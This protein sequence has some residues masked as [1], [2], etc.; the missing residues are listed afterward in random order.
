MPAE[1]ISVVAVADDQNVT[2]PADATAA[3]FS[4]TGWTS[5]AGTSLGT[6]TLG[7]VVPDKAQSR[8]ITSSESGTG[9][10]AWR[11]PPTGLQ[12]LVF[13]FTPDDPMDEGPTCFVTF[14]KGGDTNLLWRDPPLSD[15][16]GP[17]TPVSV[18]VDTVAGDLVVKHDQRFQHS[19]GQIPGLSSG[20]TSGQTMENNQEGA[21]LSYIVATGT[22]QVCDSEDEDFSTVLAFAIPVAPSG[23]GTEFPTSVSHFGFGSVVLIRQIRLA[24]THAGAGAATGANTM[25]LT[26]LSAST[27]TGSVSM[28]R[29]IGKTLSTSGTA[30]AGLV[31]VMARTLVYSGTGSVATVAGLLT[32]VSTT[33]SGT[34]AVTM[35]KQLIQFV[36][37]SIKF[38]GRRLFGLMRR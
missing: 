8:A 21:R 31:K 19:A 16:A 17:T 25:V 37:S 14:V 38:V 7:G 35:T 23:G 36:S 12:A 2:V 24:K 6:I 4:W 22:T 3:Y 30:V 9:A 5:T 27:G 18:T 34:A 33:F 20:W 28:G 29:L 26:Q 15:A 13:G 11:N 32:S 1:V 10:V